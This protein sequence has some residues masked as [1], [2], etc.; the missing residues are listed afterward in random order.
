MVLMLMGV[1]NHIKRALDYIQQAPH[2]VMLG[3]TWLSLECVNDEYEINLCDDVNH[4]L[5]EVMT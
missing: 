1:P 3:F 5:L 2:C 4:I